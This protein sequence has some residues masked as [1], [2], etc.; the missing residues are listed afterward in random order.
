MAAPDP[1]FGTD[2]DS[3]FRQRIPPP[4]RFRREFSDR[5]LPDRVQ[6]D[7]SPTRHRNL[8]SQRIAVPG[9]QGHV[10]KKQEIYGQTFKVANETATATDRSPPRPRGADTRNVTVTSAPSRPPRSPMHRPSSPTWSQAPSVTSTSTR[11][12]SG[13]IASDTGFHGG[14]SRRSSANGSRLSDRDSGRSSPNGGRG[15]GNGVEKDCHRSLAQSSLRSGGY[16]LSRDDGRSGGHGGNHTDAV[17]GSGSCRKTSPGDSNARNQRQERQ[18]KPSEHRRRSHDVKSTTQKASVATKGV[19][20]YAGF[21]PRKEA[22]NV[23]GATFTVANHSADRLHR[24]PGE[25]R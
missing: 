9:Y 19:V 15:R 5:P 17:R 7:P 11:P 6:W 12:L 2:T 8:E 21:I 10:P 13:S 14:D 18:D 4:T 1:P 3:A 25:R 24:A 22:D 20:G 16:G 23:Y